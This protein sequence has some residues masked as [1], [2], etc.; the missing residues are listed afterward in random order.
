MVIIVLASIGQ[1]LL[2]VIVILLSEL[3]G[4]ILIC[5]FFWRSLLHWDFLLHMQGGVGHWIEVQTEM[6]IKKF[7]ENIIKH[8]N[9]ECGSKH[10]FSPN[11]CSDFAVNYEFSVNFMLWIEHISEYLNIKTSLH[12]LTVKFK[13]KLVQKLSLFFIQH[14]N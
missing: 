1:H 14:V 12:N 11:L 7:S 9:P 2:V 6:N 8:S 3:S 5:R 10:D 13:K 4:I